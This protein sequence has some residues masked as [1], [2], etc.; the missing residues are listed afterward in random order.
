MPDMLDTHASDIANEM[1]LW[2]RC[3]REYDHHMHG[4]T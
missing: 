2:Q 3:R 4:I 1:E